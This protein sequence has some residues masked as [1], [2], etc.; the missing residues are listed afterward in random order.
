M[1]GTIRAARVS[2]RATVRSSVARCAAV[3]H[4]AALRRPGL[5]IGGQPHGQIRGEEPVGQGGDLLEVEPA[6]R[7][8]ADVFDHI[9]VGE[10]GRVCAQADL[11]IGQDPG[12]L[13]PARCL[14][15]RVRETHCPLQLGP[16]R[17]V[18]RVG[19]PAPPLGQQAR[20]Q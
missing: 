2:L 19:L 15:A 5:V 7:E 16:D 11:G 14:D 4:C 10:P 20:G 1:A 12:D 6:A 17:Q 3:D 18:D 8:G 9:G 13:L